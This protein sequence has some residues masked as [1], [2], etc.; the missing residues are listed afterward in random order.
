MSTVVARRLREIAERGEARR[1][2]ISEIRRQSDLLM[3]A[4]HRLRCEH[5]QQVGWGTATAVMPG[6]PVDTPPQNDALDRV[7]A[8]TDSGVLGQVQQLLREIDIR[9]RDHWNEDDTLIL[10]CLQ[11]ALAA[12]IRKGYALQELQAI[13]D[14]LKPPEMNV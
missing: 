6:V 7:V 1:R 3:D 14:G 11:S 2:R 10:I 13:L 12:A 4:V 9:E 5:C 8:P